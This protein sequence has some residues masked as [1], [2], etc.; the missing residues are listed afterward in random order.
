V[1]IPGLTVAAG[2]DRVSEGKK[3]C[4]ASASASQP[5]SE[6][7]ELEVEHG[8]DLGFISMIK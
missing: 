5:F 8:L 1:G 3:P 6:K 2:R 7:L 4:G